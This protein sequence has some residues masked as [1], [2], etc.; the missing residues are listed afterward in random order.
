MRTARKSGTPPSRSACR[1]FRVCP[2]EIRS[3]RTANSV[4]LLLTPRVQGRIRRARP[5]VRD[6]VRVAGRA[7][8]A[9]QAGPAAGRR[10]QALPLWP[11]PNPEAALIAGLAQSLA[12]GLTEG[13]V[14]TL[15]A[16][17]RSG[18][19][20]GHRGESSTKAHEAEGNDQIST[21]CGLL[22]LWTGYCLR[23]AASLTHVSCAHS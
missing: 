23:V 15:A 19:G 10:A 3:M 16:V 18:G 11:P 20:R 1:T 2:G 5:G 13:A 7:G 4:C 12:A 14:A 9:Q 17:C 8:P 21:H 6:F 22:G